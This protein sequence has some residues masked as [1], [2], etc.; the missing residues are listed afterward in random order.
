[1]KLTI[2]G[3]NTVELNQKHYLTS[4]GEGKIY[5]KDNTVYKV[6]EDGKM[7]PEGKINELS[8]LDKPNIIKPEN[9]LLDSKNKSVGY[10]MKFIP[11]T[12]VLCQLFNK[13]FRTRNSINENS[14]FAL[15]KQMQDTIEFI[16]SRNILLVDLNELNFLVDQ[17][18]KDVFFIDVNSYQTKSYPATAI[19]DSVRDR[20]CNNKFTKDTDW[21]SFAIISFQMFIGIHPFKGKHPKYIDFNERMLANVSILDSQVKYPVAACQPLS[22]IPKVYLDWYKAVFEQGKRIAPPNDLINTIKVVAVVTK[23]ITG[24]NLFDIKEL[25]DFS[26]DIMY[27]VN[28]LREVILTSDK[29]FLDKNL[30]TNIKIKNDS[31]VFFTPKSIKPILADI[32]NGK[33]VLTDVNTG[34]NI[35]INLNTNKI[36]NYDGRLYALNNSQILEIQL[37]ELQNSIIASTIYVANVLEQSLQFFDGVIVQNLFDSYYISLFPASKECRQIRLTELSNHKI[38]DAKFDKKILIVI[39]VDKSG[40]YHRFIFSFNNKFEYTIAKVEDI[41]FTGI[42]FVVLDNDTCILINES[43]ELEIFKVFNLLNVKKIDDPLI[44]SDMKLYSKGSQV[45]FTKNCKLFSFAMK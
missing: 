26:G 18:F 36:M 17:Q 44:S 43:E 42:N 3:K 34:A 20:H 39:A 11:D 7:I 41:T 10:T 19:M 35:P 45:L 1:M 31:K 14:M 27:Y 24:N 28:N 23:T 6:C 38:I 30:K 5:V 15:I 16:H 4:G 32:E 33:L 22:V 8:P 29:I 25:Y 13:S 40:K 12:Y 37:I 21:F 2:K 9:I